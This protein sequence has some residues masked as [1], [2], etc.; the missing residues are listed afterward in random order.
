MPRR[1]P[2][3]ACLR[4]VLLA[5]LILG[6]CLQP[7][8]AAACDVED[9]R[10]AFEH[11]AETA[12]SAADG[13]R[14]GDPADCCA[15]PACGDC[16]LHA[17]ASLPAIPQTSPLSAPRVC[18]APLPDGFAPCDYPVDSRPPIRS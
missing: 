10:I 3:R 2:L 12:L 8:F 4:L 14:T 5:M 17:T 18:G 15:N 7:T 13:D 6:V 16:C 1:A 9:A 11:G